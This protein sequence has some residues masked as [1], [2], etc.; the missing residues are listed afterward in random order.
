MTNADETGRDEPETDVEYL[1]ADNRPLSAFDLKVYGRAGLSPSEAS[2]WAKGRVTP[3]QAETFRAADIS[4]DDAVAYTAEG[5]RAGFVVDCLARGLDPKAEWVEEQRRRSNEAERRRI[6]EERR[7]REERDDGEVPARSVDG[8]SAPAEEFLKD[9]AARLER[10]SRRYLVSLGDIAE[11]AGTSPPMVSKWRRRDGF[12]EPVVSGKSPRFDACEVVAFLLTISTSESVDPL[13]GRGTA[14]RWFTSAATAPAEWLWKLAVRNLVSREEREEP[15]VAMPRSV[16]AAVGATALLRGVGPGPA[17]LSGLVDWSTGDDPEG[18]F[19]DLFGSPVASEPEGVLSFAGAA[20][21]V[22]QGLTWGPALADLVQR[23][24]EAIEDGLS[25]VA[26]IEDGLTELDAP[27]LDSAGGQT[28]HALAELMVALADRGPGATVLDP[29]L[30]EGELLL[31]MAGAMRKSGRG[32]ASG[33]TFLGQELDEDVAAI[34]A[35]RFELRGIDVDLRVGDSFEDDAFSERRAD[36]VL[37]DPPFHESR[38]S[39]S[40]WLRYASTH[41]ADDGRAVVVLPASA[42]PQPDKGRAALSELLERREVEAI[43]ML[44]PPV[45]PG[46]RDFVAVCVIGPPGSR[47]EE[48]IVLDYVATTKVSRSSRQLAPSRT[49]SRTEDRLP[50]RAI[51]RELDRNRVSA[52][53]GDTAERSGGLPASI[54]RSTDFAKTGIQRRGRPRKSQ[55]ERLARELLKVLGDQ[56]DALDPELRAQLE[57]RLGKSE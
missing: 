10:S 17:P 47:F 20:H 7:R 22:R 3:Y 13:Q 51:L 25:T 11:F 23:F 37:I 16:V 8:S 52:S 15:V 34:A 39:P 49:D 36:V 27:G 43:I 26:L 2:Q 29:A 21:R 18:R 4:L 6:E 30:G 31:W 40:D 1:G 55:A 48:V 41:L 44:P 45:R 14:T 9:V 57:E 56:P 5:M 53:G 54:F 12:P 32:G 38:P 35:V 42:I 24:D 50:I 33:A 28:P 19:A 46:T